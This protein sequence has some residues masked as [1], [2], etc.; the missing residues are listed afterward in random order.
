MR[1]AAS[2]SPRWGTWVAL[3]AVLGGIGYA[4]VRDAELS[5]QAAFEPQAAEPPVMEPRG[6][7]PQA[8]APDLAPTTEPPISMLVIASPTTVRPDEPLPLTFYAVN[9]TDRPLEVLRSLDGS[10]MGWRYPKIDLEIRDA[11]GR[12]VEGA[13]VGRCG[14][15]NSLAASD[16]VELAPG[17][18]TKLVGDGTFGHHRLR[19][20]NGLAPG[21]YTVTLHYDLRFDGPERATHEDG[22]E[23]KVAALPKG[24]YSSPP[25]TIEVK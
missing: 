16:F 10:D 19:G 22:I 15:V 13:P 7:E 5:A 14:L 18:R 4:A 23:A 8:P 2:H 11:Q 20:P 24:M 3:T 9:R 12:L 17:A 6:V 1:I 21:V 25:I